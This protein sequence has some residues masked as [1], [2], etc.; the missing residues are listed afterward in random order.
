MHGGFFEMGSSGGYFD[1]ELRWDL[2]GSNDGVSHNSFVNSFFRIET[3]PTNLGKW[4]PWANIKGMHVGN[5]GPV[6]TSRWYRFHGGGGICVT[7]VCFR[8]IEAGPLWLPT[9]V[10]GGGGGG[11]VG[12]R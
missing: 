12:P 6:P 2:K 5:V 11:P 1:F 9:Q 10:C 8:N 3:A 7:D 4:Q